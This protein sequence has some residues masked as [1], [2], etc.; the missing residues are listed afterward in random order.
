MPGQNQ[1][2]PLEPMVFR[3]SGIVEAHD[4]EL[5]QLRMEKRQ[6]RRQVEYLERGLEN[7]SGLAQQ[8]PIARPSA[9]YM[10]SSSHSMN[11]STMSANEAVGIP[12]LIALT[13]GSNRPSIPMR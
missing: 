11:R 7:L 2:N 6:L 1:D 4:S 10:D 12:G 8:R 13:T 3:L 5:E 9:A